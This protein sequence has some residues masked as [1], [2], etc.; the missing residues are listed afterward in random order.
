LSVVA[1][2]LT[3]SRAGVLI[4]MTECVLLSFVLWRRRNAKAVA[5]LVL[6]AVLVVA[7]LPAA[8][9]QRF[10]TA[11]GEEQDESARWRQ[12]DH[13]VAIRYIL[14]HPVM[15]AGLGVD[16]I[17]MDQ[18]RS[19]AIST[20]VHNVFLAYGV[21]LGLPGLALFVALLVTCYR[22]VRRAERAQAS[23]RS[24]L[25][26]FAGAVRISL[27]GFVVAGFFAPIPYHFHYYYLTGLAVAV[28][29]LAER[30][31]KAQSA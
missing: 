1:I 16:M 5:A 9:T 21:D 19:L 2:V 12:A 30:R 27:V 22:G 11:F 8:L 15:G 7:L 31:S 26:A 18:G 17:A 4:L 23:R 20:H 24:E 28:Q 10:A 25:G 6:G 3:F 13:G 14:T 29:G